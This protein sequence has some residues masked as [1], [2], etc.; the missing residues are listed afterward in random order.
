MY[1]IEK[2]NYGVKL[3]FDGFIKRDEMEAWVQEAKNI[4]PQLSGKFGV[5]VDMRTLKP[6]PRDSQVAMEEGQK[7]FKFNGME[8]SVV[9]LNSATVTMQFKKIAK[10]TGIDQWE[11]YIDA[12]KHAD[13]ETK[14]LDWLQ[15]GK[16][17]E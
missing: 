13:W 2:K 3:T 4:V 14:S 12:S 8:R 9:I 5:L 10:D 11:R 15:H 1:K 17:P 6:L 16:D 7:L